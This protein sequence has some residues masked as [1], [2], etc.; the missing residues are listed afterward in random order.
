MSYKIYIIADA[1]RDL[2]D[3]FKYVVKHDS[4]V[5]AE[6]L[7]ANL[8]TTCQSLADF[9]QRGHTPPELGRIGVF[10][11]K[12]IHYKP[13]RIIYQIITDRVYVHCILDG[14]RD[15]QDLLQKRLLR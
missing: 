8:Q 2:V 11:Y 13:Y 9:A 14:R 12:E 15:L 10:E 5:K 7:L 6:Q 1:E 3:L 4:R